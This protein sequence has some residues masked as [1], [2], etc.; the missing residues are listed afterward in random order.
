MLYIITKSSEIMRDF[1]DTSKVGPCRLNLSSLTGK[2]R[3]R[4]R[5]DSKA[6]FLILQSSFK[7]SKNVYLSFMYLCKLRI[8]AQFQYVQI[9]THMYVWIAF[10]PLNNIPV[11]II[12][13]NPNN[14]FYF[15]SSTV[16]LEERRYSY[17][18]PLE[19]NT[20]QWIIVQM[21]YTD[22]DR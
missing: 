9:H 11:C 15:F 21:Y 20:R 16:W 12:E 4:W 8:L 17:I 19:D 5:L 22:L 10:S 2:W 18:K 1:K 13:I 3:Q 7:S 6:H 14:K